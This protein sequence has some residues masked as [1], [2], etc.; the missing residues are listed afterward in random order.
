MLFYLKN[1]IFACFLNFFARIFIFLRVLY[2]AISVL[3]IYTVYSFKEEQLKYF[4]IFI[5]MLSDIV[6]DHI[7][8]QNMRKSVPYRS[9]EIM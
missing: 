5:N 2:L 6:K 7:E 9:Y 8:K 1:I 3:F 4:S